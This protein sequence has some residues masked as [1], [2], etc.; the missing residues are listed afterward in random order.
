MDQ[1]AFLP[2]TTVLSLKKLTKSHHKQEK[3]TNY[4]II[5]SYTTKLLKCTVNVVHCSFT[6]AR[7]IDARQTVTFL[8]ENIAGRK[9]NEGS[10][11]KIYN[12]RNNWHTV[13]SQHGFG[14]VQQTITKVPVSISDMLS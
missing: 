3:Y 6:T 10:I 14:K 5:S 4:L 1:I 2:A 13:Y 11:V 9:V 7:C 8:K 12:R